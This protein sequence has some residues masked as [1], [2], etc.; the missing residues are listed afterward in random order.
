M[1]KPTEIKTESKRNRAMPTKIAKDLH[2]RPGG[3]VR[4]SMPAKVANDLDTFKKGV[5][6]FAEQ[7]GCPECFSGF[8]CTFESERDFIIDERLNVAAPPFKMGQEF[9][10]GTKREVTVQMAP[11]N[12]FSLEWIL[13]RIDILGKNLGSHWE[14]GGLALCCSG[15]DVTFGREVEYLLDGGGNLN[16]AGR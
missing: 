11:A 13:G 8:D 5:V 3:A 6:A 10:R 12:E 14:Q 1:Y 2:R 9:S 4:I 15:F 16:R 7:L